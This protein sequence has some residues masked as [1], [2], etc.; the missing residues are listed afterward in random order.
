VTVEPTLDGAR[1]D[2]DIIVAS[3][4]V[5]GALIMC[6]WIVASVFVVLIVDTSAAR[7]WLNPSVPWVLRAIYTVLAISMTLYFLGVLGLTI[8]GAF[9]PRPVVR[10]DAEGLLDRRISAAVIPWS[11][12][13]RVTTYSGPTVLFD[14]RT[15]LRPG[16]TSVRVRFWGMALSRLLRGRASFVLSWSPSPILPLGTVRTLAERHGAEWIHDKVGPPKRR[17]RWSAP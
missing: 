7:A 13:Q 15:P 10:L 5:V 4:S 1:N 8:R 17:W 16:V 14:L 3:P 6:L 2:G 9:L 12:I 11:N